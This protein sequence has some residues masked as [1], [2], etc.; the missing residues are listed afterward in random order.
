MAMKINVET[1]DGQI[2]RVEVEPTDTIKEVKKKIKAEQ[3]MSIKRKY[4]LL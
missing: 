4:T 2:L 3:G 1:E